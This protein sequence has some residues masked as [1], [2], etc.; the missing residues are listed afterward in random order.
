M[1][2]LVSEKYL[3]TLCAYFEEEVSG[4]AY[5][6]GL[7]PFLGEGT[8]LEL[9]ARMEHQ[10]AASVLPLIKKY[11]LEPR[12]PDVLEQEGLDHVDRH[13]DLTWQGFMHHIVSY[14]P[15]YLEEFAALEAMAPKADLAYLKKLSRHE[16]LAIEF[17]ERELSKDPTSMDSLK[18]YLDE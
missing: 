1:S 9:L 15:V 12:T 11:G 4:E 2:R 14:Y 8:K 10:A 16:V 7:I 6:R 17:A 5:F 18:A 3:K 13:K